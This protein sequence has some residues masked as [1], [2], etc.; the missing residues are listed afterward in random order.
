[1]MRPSTERALNIAQAMA[2]AVGILPEWNL[3]DL[4]ASMDAPEL[5]ADIGRAIEMA[6]A[7]ETRWRGK[8]SA[9]AAKGAGGGLGLARYM[10]GKSQALAPIPAP[11]SHDPPGSPLIQATGPANL[12]R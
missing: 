6:A 12:P 9:E 3:A 4:Y 11:T 10:R 7:F 5:A 2:P 8:L 1:M